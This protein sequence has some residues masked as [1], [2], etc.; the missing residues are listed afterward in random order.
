M[1]VK[2]IFLYVYHVALKC[3]LNTELIKLEKKTIL[4]NKTKIITHF[5]E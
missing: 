2:N 3:L 4:F 5:L 1:H